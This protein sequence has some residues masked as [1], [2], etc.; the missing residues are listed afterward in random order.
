MIATVSLGAS[1]EVVFRRKPP[2]PYQKQTLTTNNGGLY[3]MSRDSQDFWDHSV[4]K[5]ERDDFK[6]LR[7]SITFRLLQQPGPSKR[8]SLTTSSQSSSPVLPSPTF[9][10]K[11]SQPRRVLV[12]SDS[13]NM[14][15]DCSLLK[16]PVIAFRENLFHLR[17]L[18]QHHES[19][20]QADIVLI[21]AGI[22]DMRHRR[23]DPITLHNH[24]KHF[25]EQYNTQFIF[26]AV[27]PLTM[28]ADRF[29]KLN[30]D[31]DTLNELLLQLSLR[32]RNFKLFENTSFGLAHLARDGIH[33]NDSGKSVLSSCWVHAILVSLGFRTAGLPLRKSFIKI[34]HD[35]YNKRAG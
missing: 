14:T 8:K 16:E 32:S 26:D 19:I 15:F 29:N 31:I 7:V 18:Y 33:F 35:F 34:V 17:D 22:N 24:L 25:T 3:I 10:P 30:N 1:R 9:Q 11:S 20:A 6:G 2:S 27:S 5:V 28:H 13:K 23:V 12:L 4:P 21:S